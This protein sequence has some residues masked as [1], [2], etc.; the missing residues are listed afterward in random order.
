MKIWEIHKLRPIK[1][2]HTWNCTLYDNHEL[3]LVT[4]HSH[5]SIPIKIKILFIWQQ[6]TISSLYRFFFTL[7]KN[8]LTPKFLFILPVEIWKQNHPNVN[9][10]SKATWYLY[11]NVQ[12]N[13]MYTLYLLISCGREPGGI[14]QEKM[15]VRWSVE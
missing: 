15:T 12:Q 6:K 1:F 4:K 7:K 10:Y 5:V 3:S 2:S 11:M 8:S 14:T 9:K 13:Y